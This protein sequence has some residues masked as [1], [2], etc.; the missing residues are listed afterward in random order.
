M[1][2]SIIIWVCCILKRRCIRRPL[3]AFS[4]A[5]S[6]DAHYEEAKKNLEKV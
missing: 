3:N 5:L 2:P 6:I 4:D 1:P